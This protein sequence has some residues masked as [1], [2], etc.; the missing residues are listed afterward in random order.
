[1]A[2]ES[3]HTLVDIFYGHISILYETFVCCNNHYNYYNYIGKIFND[4]E[5]VYKR[6]I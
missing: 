1:M 5:N 2:Y 3:I 6:S 4:S